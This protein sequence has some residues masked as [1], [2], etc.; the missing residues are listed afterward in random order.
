MMEWERSETPGRKEIGDGR[1]DD[2][3]RREIVAI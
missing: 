1:G 3:W 2:G